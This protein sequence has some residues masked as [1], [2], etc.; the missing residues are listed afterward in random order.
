MHRVGKGRG[1]D[2]RAIRESLWGLR[3]AVGGGVARTPVSAVVC[4]SPRRVVGV[5]GLSELQ[6]DRSHPAHV[7]GEGLEHV[8]TEPHDGPNVIA[9]TFSEEEGAN[10]SPRSSTGGMATTIDQR[11]GAETTRELLEEIAGGSRGE[12]LRA[13]VLAWNRGAT[14]DQV[15]EAFQEACARAARL[16]TG[17]TIG[18]VYV[19]L[20]TTTHR[21]VGEMRERLKREIPVDAS[22]ATLGSNH[23]ALASPVDA[24]IERE[25]RDEVDRLTLALL[26]R[27]AERDRNIAV[28]HSNGFTRNEIARH[29][30][31]S[32]RVVKRSVEG[33]LATGRE[34][35]VRLVGFGCQDGHELVARYAFGLAAN[36]E[37]RRAQLHLTS[38]ARCGAMYERLDAWRDRVA[39]LLP[40]PPTVEGHAHIVERAIHTG[41]DL[42]SSGHPTTTPA[43]PGLRGQVTSV[44]GHLRDQAAAAY[45]RTVDP[46]PLAGARPGAVAAAVAGCLA[47]G[48]GTTYC[49]QQGADPL[50]ALAVLGA[51][52][53][54]RKHEPKPKVHPN[55]AHAAQVPAPPVVT[56]TV[57]APPQTVQQPPPAPAASTTTTAAP[58][59][60][61]EDQF[62]PTSAGGAT[63]PSEPATGSSRPTKPAPAPAGG[64]GEFGG[65]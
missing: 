22:T 13:T 50:R 49:V 1:P 25:D 20:R 46:T 43:P 8:R 18:E 36:R 29:V 62:E 21:A 16:C 4:G 27:L 19:W 6:T 41:S 24:L 42:L 14:R 59:P 51:S 39:A 5:V 65:P 35:L 64:A 52:S 60:A 11:P 48:G 7:S 44:A 28:L 26:D 40:V 15:E 34:Q 56:P 9:L 53:H 63:E 57:A 55:R 30:G 23:A 3:K 10:F 38:C 32:P 54:K 45:Y 47:V 37:A 33:I 12:A 61:P 31:V 2:R 17:Q 58:P